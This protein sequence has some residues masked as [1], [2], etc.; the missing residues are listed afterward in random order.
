[1]RNPHLISLLGLGL[2][3]I[4]L[5][6]VFGSFYLIQKPF[7]PAAA[8]AIVNALLDLLAAGWIGLLGLGLGRRLLRRLNLPGSFK[9]SGK[10]EEL[11]SG[12]ILVLSTA[13]GLGALGLLTLGLGL[14]GLFYRWLFILLSLVATGLLWP[15]FMALRRRLRQWPPPEAHPGRLTAIYVIFVGLFILVTALLPPIDWD[16]LFYHLTAPK[17][18][19]QMGRISPGIDV[20]HFNFPFL[21]EMLFAYGMLLRGDIAAK[22]IHALYAF[23]LTGLVYLIARRHLSRES[24]WPSVLVLLSMPMLPTL[25]GWAY[26][27][28]ALAFY[29][30]AALYALLRSQGAVTSNQK[31]VDSSQKSV[32]SSQNLNYQLPIPKGHAVTNYHPHWLILSG[33]FA[34]LAMG[35][36]YTGFVAPLIIGSILLWWQIKPQIA[37]RQLQSPISNLQLPILYFSLPALLVALPW[38][39]KNFFF[40][41]NPF[42]PF[43]AGWFNGLYWDQFRAEWYA[44]AGSGIGFDLPRLLELPVMAMLGIKDVNYFDGRTGPLFLAFLPLMIGYGLF[45]YRAAARPPAVNILLIFA[46]IQFCFWTLGVICRA[47]CGNLG[48]CCPVWWC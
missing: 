12:E 24:A 4:W 35:L 7:T 32:D 21:A 42:Y 11:S 26:N 5:F 3:L 8:L 34:G 33:I 29:Q 16:G 48:C 27:D 36:K 1:M 45:R 13:L 47:R 40:T 37:S 30:V 44:Q 17:L 19:I 18:F 14:A 46:L 22:L 28:L 39:L 9:T 41:G 2:L 15:D 31:S 38:Y 43:A 23:L 6:G 20:P 25:A 10:V